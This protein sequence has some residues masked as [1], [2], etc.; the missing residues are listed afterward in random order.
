IRKFKSAG[1]LTDPG[2]VYDLADAATKALTV[3]DGLGSVKKLIGLASDVNK[4][5]TKRMTFTTMQTAPDPDDGN[6]VVVGAGAETLFEAIAGDRSLTGPGGKPAATAETS[7]ATVPAWQI[8]VT[9]ENGTAVTGRAAAIAAALTDQG[10]SSGTTTANAP[11]PSATTTLTYGTGQEAEARTVA[12]ALKLPSARLK[13][14]TTTGLTLVVGSDWPGGTSYPGG[15][16]PDPSTGTRTAADGAHAST[17]DQ[18]KACAKVSPYRTVTLNGVSM[19][20]SEA[21]AAAGGRPDSDG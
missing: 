8:A 18:A 20:P 19:T 16:S 1:T 14:G 7:A 9:V 5:P 11:S 6:R 21:Y 3:D 4:V 17:A 15:T 13:Q 10:F 2:A 12:E